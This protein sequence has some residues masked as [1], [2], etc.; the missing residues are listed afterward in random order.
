M[1]FAA[2]PAAKCADVIT[3]VKAGAEK[4]SIDLTGLV[5]GDSR[6][7]AEFKKTLEGDLERSGWFKIAQRGLAGTIVSG[8]CRES[9]TS[10]GVSCAVTDIGGKILLSTSYSGQVEQTRKLAH[11]A[12]DDILRAVK[13]VR[14]MASSRLAIVGTGTGRKEIYTCDSDGK[15]LLRVTDDGAIG[16]M[17]SW[18]ATADG[19]FFTS[20]RAGFPYIYSLDL[21]SSPYAPKQITRFPGLN[22]SPS[23]S[24]DGRSLAMALSK[25]GNPD[26]Y[27]MDLRSGSLS[28]VTRTRNAAEASPS[29]SPDGKKLV[30]TS[31]STGRPHLY[32]AD[33]NG[34]EARRLTFRGSEN[35]A[36]DWGR[37]GVIAYSS[38]RQGLYRICMMDP[39]TGED[40]AVQLTN[41]QENYEDPSWA[42]DGRHIAC[43]RS[44]GSGSDIYVLDS[45]DGSF[46]RLFN[47]KGNWYSPAW[48]PK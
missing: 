14:G 20:F 46:I 15:N 21:R 33:R 44:A 19:L 16:I 2:G 42:P 28:R 13:G 43:A 35:V 38:L 24:P 27:V 11:R 37:N 32:I 10:I 4:A 6:A 22:A 5:T 45:M 47:A 12:A 31:D 26:I 23:L 30:F 34:G 1:L 25:D 7:G 41:D 18:N 29:W 3:I 36:P 40:K 48:S 9:D 39:A 17:P 8:V